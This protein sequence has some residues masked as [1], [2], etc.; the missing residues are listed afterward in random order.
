LSSFPAST[1]EAFV[2]TSETKLDYNITPEKDNS[3]DSKRGLT[4]GI[5]EAILCFAP[6][7]LF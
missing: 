5:T 7:H 2:L 6:L 3:T 1:R 4:D